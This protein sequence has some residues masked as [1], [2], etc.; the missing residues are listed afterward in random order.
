MALARKPVRKELPNCLICMGGEVTEEISAVSSSSPFALECNIDY[1]AELMEPFTVTL[2]RLLET[3][4]NC[5]KA[6]R[7]NPI[8]S[9]LLW[10]MSGR[11][12]QAMLQVY[13]PFLRRPGNT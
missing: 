12:F 6:L 8:S 4:L 7:T 1:F 11:G 5:P 3:L 10:V 9:C 13:M 2:L